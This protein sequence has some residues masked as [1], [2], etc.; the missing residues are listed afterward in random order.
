MF[1]NPAKE[2]R[3]SYAGINEGMATAAG[4]WIDQGSPAKPRPNQ[5]VRPLYWPFAWFTPK[6]SDTMYMNQ[7]FYVYLLR[8][9]TLANFR[10]HLEALTS[11]VVP[12][13][14]DLLTT[15]NAYDMALDTSTTGFG[16]NFTQTWAW[17]V[18]DRAYARTADGWLWPNE[19]A[20]TLP[21]TGYVLDASLFDAD[22]NVQITKNDCTPGTSSLDCS[23]LLSKRYPL[24]PIVVSANVSS[25]NLP[26]ALAG[27]ALT[28]TFD[29][30]V[31]GGTAAFTVFGEKNGKG[32]AAAA[33]RSPEGDSVTLA[34]VGTDY[35]TVR[36]VVVPSGAPN[37]TM[38]VEMSFAVPTAAKVWRLCEGASGTTETYGCIGWDGDTTF[39]DASDEC[40]F[41]GYMTSNAQ[42]TTKAACTAQC[43]TTANATSWRTC[44]TPS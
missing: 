22:S 7:D 13:N 4:Y 21:G 36:V 40:L 44:K 38:M 43:V 27:K 24:G 26:S 3:R 25:L 42:F 23:V 16:G 15:L 17:Y 2:C 39:T 8:V 19:P 10:M 30:I 14:S 37:P 1:C 28:G 41:S 12:A 9:G 6:D 5:T 20:G 32:S 34:N 11:A 33:V 29:A 31:S 18:A 35:P